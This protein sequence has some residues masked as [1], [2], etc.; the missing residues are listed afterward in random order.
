MFV[1]VAAVVTVAAVA[2][3][4]VIAVVVVVGGAAVMRDVLALFVTVIVD[5]NNSNIRRGR[6]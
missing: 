2:I 3:H 5:C 4:D 6:G 1:C